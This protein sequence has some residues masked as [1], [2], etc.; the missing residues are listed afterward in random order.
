MTATQHTLHTPA[1]LNALGRLQRLARTVATWLGAALGNAGRARLPRD[2]D[3][4]L[5]MLDARTLRDLGFD[6]SELVS[7]A[8]DSADETRARLAWHR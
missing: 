2:I 8:P 5:S 1:A 4:A 6:R 7:S 3:Q